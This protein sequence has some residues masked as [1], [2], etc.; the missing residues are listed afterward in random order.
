MPVRPKNE[1]N[2]GGQGRSGTL[3][4]QRQMTYKLYKN[5]DRDQCL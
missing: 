1:V 2:S 5:G 3:S 4:A